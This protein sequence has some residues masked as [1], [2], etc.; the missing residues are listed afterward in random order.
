MAKDVD[1]AKSLFE[2]SVSVS[3][4]EMPRRSITCITCIFI[5]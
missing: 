1:I 3:E 5:S 2:D 4:N